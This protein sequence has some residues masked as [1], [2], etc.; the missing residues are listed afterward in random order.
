MS[1][2]LK[3]AAVDATHPWLGLASF[4][5]ETRA[6][7]HGR[8][9]EVAELGRRVQRK[10]LTILFGQSGLGK[11][12]IL[13]AGIVPRLRPEGYCPVY[14]RI[15]YGKDSPSPA[16]Q[17][18]QAI[19]R[20]TE[21][22]GHWTQ[23]G[24]A[25][26]GE[27][28]WEFLHHRDDVLR[29]QA[30]RTLVPLL[31]F[32]QFEE[33]FTLA[34]GDDFGRQR[35][36]QFIDE[37]ADLVENRAPRAL[38]A[39]LEADEAGLD[40]FD[41][42]RADYRIL[43]AL[44]E[45]Y[46]AHLEGLKVRMPS[47]TQ[48]R[49]RLAR[50]TGAQAL[51]AVTGPG[52]S[53]VSADVAAAI[54]RFVAGGAE[55]ER[56]EVEPSLL[57][58]VCR[59]LNNTRLAQGQATIS[60]DLLAGS[61]D[62]ILSEFYERTLADQPAGVRAF[63]EDELL[64]DSGYRESIAE[65]R[66][67]KGLAAAGAAEGALA[68]LIDRRLLR[69]EERLDVRRV[70]FTH[71][72]LCG[73]VKGSRDVR[74]ERE[75]LERAERELAAQR[76]REAATQR[77]LLRARL[78]AALAG[79]LML[80]AAGSAVFGWL[81]LKRARVAEQAA[82]RTGR[83]ADAARTE[84]EKIVGFL[85][86]DF[87]RE[88]EP[89]G[90]VEIVIKL[91]ARAV[92]YYRNLPAELRTSATERNRGLTLARYGAALNAQNRTDEAAPALA[93]AVSVLEKLFASGDATPE[94]A[95]G[96]SLALRTQ[97]VLLHNQELRSESLRAAERA[98]EVIHPAATAAGAS[99]VLRLDHAVTL[100]T[101]GFQ[102]AR[103]ATDGTE[104][105]LPRYAAAKK[106]L[107]DLVAEEGAEVEAVAAMATVNMRLAQNAN[108]LGR[109][110]EA[111]LLAGESLKGFE[112]VLAQNPGYL[113]AV[114]GRGL[115]QGVLSNALLSQG[116]L[117]ESLTAALRSEEAYEIYLRLNP[118][119]GLGWGNLTMARNRASFR[120]LN[121]GR[122]QE[123]LA[124]Q[125]AILDLESKITM[126][127]ATASTFAGYA[128]NICFW[129]AQVGNRTAA[130]KALAD[131]GRFMVR[132][133]RDTGE[134]SFQRLVSNEVTEI[135]R[136][137]LLDA[138][139]GREEE[140]F[141]SAQKV[142]PRVERLAAKDESSRSLKE[143]FA[144]TTRQ[145]LVGAALRSGR[146]AEAEQ[147]ARAAVAAYT[148]T[149][150]RN[151]FDRMEIGALQADQAL[152]LVRQGRRDEAR[153]L[154]AP[155]VEFYRAELP[156][157]RDDTRWLGGAAKVQYALAMAQP[158]DAAGRARR[159]GALDEA[160]QLLDGMGEMKSIR[161]VKELIDWVAAAREGR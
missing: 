84:A 6:Y 127:S 41:F 106:I 86:D 105:A 20:A 137:L 88:L 32:D 49:M 78:A 122:V 23:A 5:E 90:R 2:E 132:A 79:V 25:G 161:F 143:T 101:L 66:V 71:D 131:F 80:G 107:T 130:E 100:T 146:W 92:E 45:D 9:A 135:S 73:V 124:K 159:R 142:L 118:T 140:V 160:Q 35:A 85:V 152:A 46:L 14:V 128:I 141:Q 10:L 65:E 77:S 53:L 138:T 151:E 21:S 68:R 17:I 27:T 72:V 13:R 48:N 109:A 144:H 126:S 139:G 64:T 38:E 44:R 33:I 134:E 75:A 36:A 104:R 34:Q 112:S 24:V 148:Q 116:K 62:T 96:L 99:R 57:S 67:K 111:F 4:T 95:A 30:G 39:R 76:E 157:H 55:L 120:L 15:D 110:D 121:L 59:E 18:K 82:E 123:F 1:A 16:E 3:S 22:A 89:T 114:N 69:V 113:T 60:A 108:I 136:I 94:I 19:L 40:R 11:T 145:L 37:L 98:V 52:G 54:V 50:M 43:I 29:D 58:L 156:R 61:R 91:A 51:T 83:L 47:V 119:S 97:S 42:A 129:E 149:G 158:D 133:T 28:L 31:I 56:A 74:Q 70:E 93:E 12:S 117:T 26:Q 154:L 87:Y 115:A 81:N 153:A 63:I 102:Y 7:F 8:E 147:A 125:R 103:T 155:A 150:I